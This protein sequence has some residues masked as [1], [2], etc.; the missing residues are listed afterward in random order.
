[1]RSYKNNLNSPFSYLGHCRC[2]KLPF[3]AYVILRK[4]KKKKKELN[5]MVRGFV[6]SWYFFTFNILKK[7]N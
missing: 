2:A 4:R 5:N 3:N 1:M 7:K 6:Q